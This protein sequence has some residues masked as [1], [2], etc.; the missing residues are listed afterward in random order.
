MRRRP[1]TRRLENYRSF[2]ANVSGYAPFCTNN[3]VQRKS[4]TF[5]IESRRG[6]SVFTPRG[7]AHLTT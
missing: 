7:V 6:G 1:L 3:F 2:P 4:T 5:D